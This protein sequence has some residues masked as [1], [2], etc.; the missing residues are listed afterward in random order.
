MFH[1]ALITELAGNRPGIYYTN[2]NKAD[3]LRSQ[4]VQFPITTKNNGL[5]HKITDNPGFVNQASIHK[6]ETQN[7]I[8]KKNIEGA[9][10]RT[11]NIE[12]GSGISTVDDIDKV[13]LETPSSRNTIGDG[14]LDVNRDR[15]YQ[16]AV[17]H[18]DTGPE[19]F[20]E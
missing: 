1:Q 6:N 18:G 8:K 4:G 17:E 10:G 3:F 15:E 9:A 11:K 13:E 5:M 16:E 20:A 14:P 7:I 19:H 2:K 12:G